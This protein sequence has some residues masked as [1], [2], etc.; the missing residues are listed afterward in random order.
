M[1]HL[2]T[3]SHLSLVFPD[4]SIGLC[5]INLFSGSLIISF[6]ISNWLLNPST[7]FLISVVIIL[8][9]K[10]LFLFYISQLSGCSFNISPSFLN[11]LIIIM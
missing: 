4:A 9:S 7:T 6:A 10:I 3:V 8:S 5:S 2:F 1:L 11:I